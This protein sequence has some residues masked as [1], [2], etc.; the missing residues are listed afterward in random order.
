[1][2]ARDLQERGIHNENE[3]DH[4]WAWVLSVFCR[5]AEAAR[6]EDSTQTAC[7]HCGSNRD[8]SQENIHGAQRQASPQTSGY[9]FD[10]S[11][12]EGKL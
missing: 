5:G 1:M 9:V 10:D 4:R 6:K 7:F 8:R 11:E 12:A 3:N 2:I